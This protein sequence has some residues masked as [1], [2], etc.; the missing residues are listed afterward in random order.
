[1]HEIIICQIPAQNESN[2][3]TKY[4]IP[5]NADIDY[6]HTKSSVFHYND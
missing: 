4:T 2:K 6:S 3:S 1:M 5:V